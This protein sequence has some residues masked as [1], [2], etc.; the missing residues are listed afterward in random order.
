MWYCPQLHNLIEYQGNEKRYYCIDE[1][2]KRK[3]NLN[4]E[5]KLALGRNSLRR[6]SMQKAITLMLGFKGEEQ[7]CTAIIGHCSISLPVQSQK[8]DLHLPCQANTRL[9][10]VT[11]TFNRHPALPTWRQAKCEL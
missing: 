1:V 10:L 5:K 3:R 11:E 4:E 9:P 8:L 6:L 2:S 7:P